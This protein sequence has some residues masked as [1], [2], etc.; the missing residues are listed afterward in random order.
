MT[1]KPRR[2]H[3]VLG[4]PENVDADVTDTAAQSQSMNQ[5]MT[6]LAYLIAGVGV[7]GFLGWLIDHFVGTHLFIAIG[8]VL[9]AACAVFMIIKRFGGIGA[10]AAPTRTTTPAT[11]DPATEGSATERDRGEAR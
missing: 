7:Y 10:T 8:I 3:S 1:D 4:P 11:D 2:S 6:A 5:G 9:G